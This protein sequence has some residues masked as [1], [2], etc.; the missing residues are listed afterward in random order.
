M[1][2]FFKTKTKN[3]T[4]SVHNFNHLELFYLRLYA[5]G[6]KR[7]EICDFLE[8]CGKRLTYMKQNIAVK[9]KSKNWLKI[10]AYAFNNGL[11]NKK[12]FVEDL[13]KDQAS[14]YAKDIFINHVSKLNKSINTHALKSKIIEFCSVSESLLSN[15]YDTFSENNKLTLL[16]KKYLNLKYQ[17]L[18]NSKGKN[19]FMDFSPQDEQRLRRAIFKKL[20][21]CNWFNVFKKAIQFN[22]IDQVNSSSL[23]FD[24]Y[25]RLCVSDIIESRNIE[26]LTSTD[27]ELLIYGKL[28]EL[29]SNLEIEKLVNNG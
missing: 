12:D 26:H 25:L 28:L 24:Y 10:M 11:L 20:M 14:F 27:R 7:N 8:V 22:L 1:A 13:V 9:C 18:I 2:E 21:G 17:Y 19:Y 15:E 16:E 6:V 5:H 29:Y 3:R 23:S 4:K